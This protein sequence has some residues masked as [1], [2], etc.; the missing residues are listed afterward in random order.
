MEIKE[1]IIITLTEVADRFQK[2]ES[3]WCI[4]GSSAMI[5]SGIKLDN[6]FD[7]DILTTDKG[8][9][10]LQKSLHEYM[11]VNPV[12]KENDLFRSNFARFN[13]P[14]MNVEAMGGLQVKKNGIWQNVHISDFCEVPI[15]NMV[16]KIPTLDEQKRLLLLFGRDKDL[17]R[18]RLFD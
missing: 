8:S 2:I 6:T 1:R 3:E 12:T 13:F 14:L 5:L 4:I 9:D 7:I 10:E 18:I 16:V 17:K 11:V 15:G